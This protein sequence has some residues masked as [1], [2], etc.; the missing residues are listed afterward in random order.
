[1]KKFLMA[2]ALL[3]LAACENTMAQGLTGINATNAEFQAAFNRGDAP[4]LAK[5]YTAD[6][7]LMAPNYGRIKG[8]RAIEGLWQN[9]FDAGVSDI[10]LNTLELE[11]TGN[12]AS[13]VGTFSLT[14]PDGKG[15]RVTANGK[16][17]V[18]WRRDGDGIWRLHRDIWNNDP[19]G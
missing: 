9:F 1:M 5:L 7:L 15:G 18:L 19:G 10:D 6:S 11:V 3:A 2:M 13:E 4:G 14:A 16:Y 17:I 8:R 12:K